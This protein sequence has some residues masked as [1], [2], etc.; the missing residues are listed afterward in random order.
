MFGMLLG[1]G[2]TG[3]MM[4]DPYEH[5]RATASIA[6]KVLAGTPADGEQRWQ[7]V[8]DDERSNHEGRTMSTDTTTAPVA[9][10]PKQVATD[11][12]DVGKIFLA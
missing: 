6:R 7:R 8:L 5:G 4:N 12:H 10:A 11:I 2:V 1:Q 9:A 3:G